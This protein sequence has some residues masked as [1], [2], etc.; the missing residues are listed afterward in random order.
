MVG[1][2]HVLLKLLICFLLVDFV[3]INWAY[4][5]PRGQGARGLKFCDIQTIVQVSDSSFGLSISDEAKELNKN[6]FGD[7]VKHG[8]M[9]SKLLSVFPFFDLGD[10]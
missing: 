7:I 4:S 6:S 2:D 3:I 5:R 8:N 9:I 10:S 1:F